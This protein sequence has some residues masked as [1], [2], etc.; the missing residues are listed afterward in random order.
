MSDHRFRNPDKLQQLPFRDWL[1]A[2]FP[3]GSDGFVVEDLDLVIRLYGPNYGSDRQG[4]FML[5]ELKHGTKPAGTSKLRTFGL[6]DHLLRQA[7]PSA[8]RY[9]GFFIVRTNTD[10]WDQCDN[11]IVNGHD[12]GPESFRSWIVDEPGT[13]SIPSH[14]FPS[15]WFGDDPIAA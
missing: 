15:A 11:F 9:R 8:I 4:R 3:N 2:G 10:D 12:L 6:M 13:P 5:L 14:P 1:R 7:D